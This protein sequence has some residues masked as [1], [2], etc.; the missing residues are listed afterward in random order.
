MCKTKWTCTETHVCLLEILAKYVTSAGHKYSSL[1]V[2]KILICLVGFYGISTV[3]GYFMSNHLYIHIL[4]IWFVNTF[5]ITLWN[6]I[7]HIIWYTFKWFQVFLS[8]TNNS[9]NYWSFLCAQLNGYTHIIWKSIYN[10]L[11][12]NP[13]E[14]SNKKWTCVNNRC[15]QSK[16]SGDTLD[17]DR[18]ELRADT[19]LPEA[20]VCQTII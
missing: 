19:T 15:I 2:I 12:S 20:G 8:N 5:F 1:D 17:C 10:I 9:I 13:A 6:E 14:L 4:N 18:V 11:A 16:I 7:K 3:A